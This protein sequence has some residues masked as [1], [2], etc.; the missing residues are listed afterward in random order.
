MRILVLTHEYPPVGGGGGR[1]AQELCEGLGARGHEIQVLT[2]HWGDLPSIERS[3]S[4]TVRRLRSGRT[5]SFR[6]GMGAMLGYVLAACWMGLRLIR[7]WQ[8][9]LIHVHFA[10]PAGAAAWA[11]RL[12]TGVP[13]VLTAHLGDVPGGS[14]EKTGGWFR[15]VMPFTPP[16]WKRAAKVVAVS[17]FTRKLALVRYPV[18]IAVIPNGV[19]TGL[20]KPVHTQPGDPPTIVFAGRF[21]AQKNPLQ[22]VSS[23]SQAA[24]LPWRCVL[25]GDGVLRSQ[26]EAEIARSGLE[27][28]FTLT[29]WITPEEVLGWFAQSDILFMPSR[30]EGLPVVGVQALAM[31]LALVLGR[32]GGNVELVKEGENGYLVDAEDTAGFAAALRRLLGDRD[33]LQASQQASRALSA[34]FDLAQVLDSYERLFFEVAG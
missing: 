1:V 11:L 28:R 29:G 25:V 8:P 31:G 34:R 30:S 27:R 5:Q 21:V 14:P 20:V 18:D 13:Y 15:W 23:L 22:I 24:D 19:D 26:V 6:A 2:A 9:D 32:A 3:G 4:L 17:E 7:R 16:I 10:V 33:H 12:L